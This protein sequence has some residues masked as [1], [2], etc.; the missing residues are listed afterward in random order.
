MIFFQSSY[1][2]YLTPA[3]PSPHPSPLPSPKRAY[4]TEGL[5]PAGG[6]RAGR[7]LGRKNYNLHFTFF[8][9]HWNQIRHESESQGFL[10][11]QQFFES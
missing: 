10:L 5:L 9:L 3:P 8:I 1:T 4:A 6:L 11:L 2:V 7:P